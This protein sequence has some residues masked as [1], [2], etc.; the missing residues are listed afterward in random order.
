MLEGYTKSD[1]KIFTY[2]ISEG[3][4]NELK[5]YSYKIIAEGTGLSYDKVSRTIRKAIED[6]LVKEGIKDHH[7]KRFFITEKGI[8]TIAKLQ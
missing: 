1:L 5:S 3:R 2:L 8:N 7:T 4:T 6:G